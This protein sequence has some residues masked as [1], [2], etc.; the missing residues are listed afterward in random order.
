M[1]SVKFSPLQNLFDCRGK[2]FTPPQPGRINITK[3]VANLSGT[4]SSC[5]STDKEKAK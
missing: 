5:P 2:Y 1:G 3:P 4:G